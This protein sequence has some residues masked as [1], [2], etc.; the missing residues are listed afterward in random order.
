M[1]CNICVM[2]QWAL[3]APPPPPGSE[4]QFI[5]LISVADPFHF[6]MDSDPA[7]NPRKY[8]LLFYFFFYKNF[9][10]PKYV[11]LCC[12]WGKYLC[13]SKQSF[14]RFEKN[15]WYSNDF[16]WFMWKFSMILAD[17]LPPGS[18]WPKLNGSKRIRNT[19]T[20]DSGKCLNG[21]CA[22]GNQWIGLRGYCEQPWFLKENETQHRKTMQICLKLK[23]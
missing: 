10:S 3:R 12:L 23:C 6:D 14:K 13:H 20:N 8:Q 18:D 17:F 7:L 5:E 15:V 11:L 22:C 16:G 9:I 21:M 1:L 2:V 4:L 19:G